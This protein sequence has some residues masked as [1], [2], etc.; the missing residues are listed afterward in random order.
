[1][2]AAVMPPSMPQGSDDG[3]SVSYSCSGYFVLAMICVF[4]GLGCLIWGVYVLMEKTTDKIGVGIVASTTTTTPGNVMIDLSKVTAA[5]K[6]DAIDEAFK[7]IGLARVENALLADSSGMLVDAADSPLY[8]TTKNVTTKTIQK[9]GDE[10]Y[11]VFRKY[12]STYDTMGIAFAAGGGG[13]MLLSII[14]AF[15]SRT[16]S[17]C[18][19]LMNTT[20]NVA[21]AAAFA[22]VIGAQA[23][24]SH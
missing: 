2:N 3:K 24:V 18:R 17:G 12:S 6:K 15:L 22:A 1:M 8:I 13:G 20:S 16:D 23:S 14:M 19:M 9:D 21:T 4:V 7:K 10:V 5:S 11:A